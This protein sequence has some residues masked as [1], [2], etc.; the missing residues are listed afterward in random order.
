MARSGRL[1]ESPSASMSILNQDGNFLNTT[2]LRFQREILITA[3]AEIPSY[4]PAYALFS[5]TSVAGLHSK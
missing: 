2:L 5:L 4:R 1:C 3:P